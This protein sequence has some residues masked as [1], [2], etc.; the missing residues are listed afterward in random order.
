MIHRAADLPDGTHGE[1]WF[2]D[3]GMYRYRL[4]RYWD[5]TA[6]PQ[7][8]IMLNPSTATETDLDPT[9]R[10]CI[11]YAKRD[12]WGGVVILNLFAYRSTDPKGLLVADDPVGPANLVTIKETVTP[13]G[14]P[15]ITPQV[16]AAW[17]ANARHPKLWEPA[18]A[19]LWELGVLGIQM[20]C[21]GV[22]KR[23]DPKHPLYLAADLPFIPWRAP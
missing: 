23:L 20:D 1:A 14:C 15:P 3:D 13:V 12:G 22:T 16:V 2:S 4:I 8:W 10:R 18:A 21:L 7:I 6:V 19:I 11:G 5:I 17:G 9:I